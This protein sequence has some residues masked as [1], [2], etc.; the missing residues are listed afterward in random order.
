MQKHVKN[1][2][3]AH[4]LC[5]EDVILCEICGQVAVDIHHK[6]YRSAGGSDEADNLVALCRKDHEAAHRGEIQ[7][8]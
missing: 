2:L 6:I 4:D 8:N 3:K 5:K 7:F 1:Y